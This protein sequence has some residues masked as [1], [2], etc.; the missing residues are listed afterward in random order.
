MVALITLLML[1]LIVISQ[2]DLNRFKDTIENQVSELTGRQ[3]TIG[4]DLRI[5][6]SLQPLINLEKVSFSNASWARDPRMLSVE[7][8]QLKLDLRPLLNNVFLIEELILDG[9]DLSVETNADGVI[10]WQLEKFSS[11][12]PETTVDEYTTEPYQLAFLPIV[13]KVQLN[14]FNFYYGDAVNEIETEVALK[15]KLL[16][17][18]INEV[19]YLSAN[20]T[21]N[22]HIFNV[23]AEVD[24]LTD[25]TLQNIVDQGVNLKLNV[26]ALG[27]EL[28]IDGVIEHPVSAEGMSIAVSIKAEDLDKT[29][30]SATG[31]S[32]YR[33]LPESK[34]K[35]PL[36]FSANLVD[37]DRGYKFNTIKLELADTDIAGD[38][39]YVNQPERPA[40]TAK[41]HSNNVNLDRFVAKLPGKA[42]QSNNKKQPIK[43]KDV[44]IDLP[45]S[46]LPFELLKSL[47][48]VVEYSI[49]QFHYYQFEPKA[50]K[51]NAS[52]DAG[53]LQ[54]KQLDLK[55]DGAPIQSSLMVDSGGKSPRINTKL[56]VDKLQLGRVLQTFDVDQFKSGL[57]KTKINLKSQGNSIKSLLLGLDGNAHVELDD[58]RVEFQVEEKLHLADINHFNLNFTGIKNPLEFDMDGSV[59]DEPLLMSGKL[60]SP[61]AIIDNKTLR[62]KLE[63][64]A[65]KINLE[66]E[67]SITNPINLES[68]ELDLSLELPEPTESILKISNIVSAVKPNKN[69]PD[70]PVN[71]R[72]FLKV[73]PTDIRFE[74]MKLNAGKSDLSGNVYT[75]LSGEKPYIEAKLESKL[76]DLNELVPATIRKDDEERLEQDIDKDKDK[77]DNKRK[78]FSTE[79]LPV[80]DGLHALDAR[81]QYKLY[82][83]TSNKQEI[84]N[85]DLN[86]VLKDGHLIIDPLSIDFSQGT[87]ITQLGLESDKKL[88]FELDTEIIKLRY[89][90]LMAILGTREYAKGEL[91]AEIKLTAKG[92]SISELMSKLYGSVRVTTVDGVLDN[93]AL[94]FLSKDLV[95]MIPFTDTSDRQKINCGVVQ[96]DINSGIVETHS[97]VVNTGA[98]SALGTGTIDLTNETLSLYVAPRSKRTSVLKIALVPVNI[99]GPL[100][101][102]SVTPDVA[103][104]TISTTKTATNISLTVV[105]GGVW[106]LAE[107]LTNDLWD[108]FVDDT[109]YCARALAGDRIEPARIKLESE[110]DEDEDD[111]SEFLGDEEDF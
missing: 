66:T 84:D 47:D 76:I 21:V 96:F 4:G 11:E 100:S 82:K 5:D 22:Q 89:D 18:A 110:D 17:P 6:F 91:D 56:N 15:L 81:L 77:K 14:D 102:P 27:T 111:E 65:L 10:N 105:T 73:T 13:K 29:F 23:S 85:I 42:E 8:L 62:L 99:T 92:E 33:Y 1:L 35:L 28:V 54:I 59:G 97:M 64:D 74:Q 52:L 39:S 3:L 107:G 38:L 93:N 43:N 94:K 46:A 80:L 19:A 63:L 12:E 57:L 30:M 37:V 48:A 67:G 53:H 98:V 25:V 78:L 20:G 31:Q 51:L 16:Q 58:G 55:L 72:G 108:K 95:S 50:I 109:D 86:L 7:R 90:R 32:L 104:S 34:K 83:L 103:G 9:V 49:D 45:D 36:S 61:L 75:D 24:F 101:S 68:A 44:A 71:I 88:N 26:D 79:P 87:I 40:F 2:L 60:D 70:V 106:L 69:I 41:L